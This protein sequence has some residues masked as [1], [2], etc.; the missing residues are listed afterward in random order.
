MPKYYLTKCRPYCNVFI[1]YYCYLLFIPTVV[2][3]HY[4]KLVIAHSSSNVLQ[5]IIYVELKMHWF[6]NAS[7]FYVLFLKKE[8]NTITRL[9]AII[10]QVHNLSM[11]K[12]GEICILESIK[13]ANSSICV[14][15]PNLNIYKHVHMV[16]EMIACCPLGQSWEEVQ[17]VTR[18]LP[19]RCF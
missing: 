9:H 7:L 2:E 5:N 6:L 17:S 4:V 3:G 16:M 19:Q 13:C 11:L 18:W 14:N 15:T 8:K 1:Y 10:C 12:Y